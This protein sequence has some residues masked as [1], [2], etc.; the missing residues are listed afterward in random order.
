MMHGLLSRLTTYT[1]IEPEREFLAK[2]VSLS[3][4]KTYLRTLAY[5]NRIESN[6]TSGD[7]IG[8]KG[9]TISL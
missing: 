7:W 6:K 1:V 4:H 5:G 2:L 3:L 8:D 9:V